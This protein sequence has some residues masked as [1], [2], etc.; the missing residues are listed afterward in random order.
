MASLKIILNTYE[1]TFKVSV[2][3]RKILTKVRICVVIYSPEQ[4]T[5]L[6]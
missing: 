3:Y 6:T 4:Y 2:F 1:I 5:K